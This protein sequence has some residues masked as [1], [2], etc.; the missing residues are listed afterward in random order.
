VLLFRIQFRAGNRPGELC[1][2]TRAG[3]KQCPEAGW[4]PR[5][6]QDEHGHWWGLLTLHGKT[7]RS[8]GRLR[9]L[10]VPPRLAK[11]VERLVAQGLHPTHIFCH[12]ARTEE[13][14]RP[15]TSIKLANRVGQWRDEALADQE[16]RLKAG[17][18]KGARIP[19]DLTL[20]SLRHTWYSAAVFEAGLSPDQAGA[21]GG[22][23]GKTVE[24]NYARARQEANLRAAIRAMRAAREMD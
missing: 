4:Q 9:E 21:V 8:T 22:T 11:A 10:W 24:K 15:W 19:R 17:T 18:L 5:F 6:A 13:K 2:A 7:T 12:P 3:T 14:T 20:Y 23:S 16:E 1:K